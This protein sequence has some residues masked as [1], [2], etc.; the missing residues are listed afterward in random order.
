MASMSFAPLFSQVVLT[1]ASVLATSAVIA[2][3]SF[4]PSFSQVVLTSTS[5]QATSAAV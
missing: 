5:V 1:S 4:A 3:V 2:S